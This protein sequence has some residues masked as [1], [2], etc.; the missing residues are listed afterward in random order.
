MKD[1]TIEITI[2]QFEEYL[3]DFRGG[4]I[5]IEEIKKELNYEG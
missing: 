1:D 3:Y 2:E 5:T 4:I